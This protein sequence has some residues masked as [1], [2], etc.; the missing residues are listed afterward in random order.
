M[1]ILEMYH[2]HH[3]VDWIVQFALKRFRLFSNLIDSQRV[4]TPSMNEW[5]G[6]SEL[7][8]HGKSSIFLHVKWLDLAVMVTYN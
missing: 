2:R 7:C 4:G 6:A 8:W 3:F 1:G 5:T